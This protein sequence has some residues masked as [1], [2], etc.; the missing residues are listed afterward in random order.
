MLF[1]E[2]LAQRIELAQIRLRDFAERNA[3]GQG[4]M[5]RDRD[6]NIIARRRIEQY[7]RPV[8]L[9]SLS[10]DQRAS[11]RAGQLYR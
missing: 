5:V 8:A 7:A 3:E 6:S 10:I 1:S 11:K 2:A 9:Q 4:I